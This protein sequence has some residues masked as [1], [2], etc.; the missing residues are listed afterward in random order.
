MGLGA[1]DSSCFVVIWLVVSVLLVG[2]EP[3]GV[4]FGVC[5]PNHPFP[6]LYKRG[7]L[8]PI[9]ISLVHQSWVLPLW[10]ILGWLLSCSHYLDSWEEATSSCP[11]RDSLTFFQHQAIEYFCKLEPS[12]RV[13]S[14]FWSFGNSH[15]WLH[16]CLNRLC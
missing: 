1:F 5:H 16:G 7:N 9:H 4:G 2:V 12:L 10:W 6:D 8:V 11:Q 14:V 13:G 3:F 15:R